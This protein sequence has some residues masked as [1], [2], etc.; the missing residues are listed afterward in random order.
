MN[1][2][3]KAHDRHYAKCVKAAQVMTADEKAAFEIWE[4]AHVT[5]DGTYSTTDWPGWEAI[6]TRIAQL[7][8]HD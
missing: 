1:D 3:Q 7:N 8:G 6:F 2:V 4:K 5:G